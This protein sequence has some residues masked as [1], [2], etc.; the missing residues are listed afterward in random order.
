[1]HII[2]LFVIAFYLIYLNF[3]SVKWK[4]KKNKRYFIMAYNFIKIEYYN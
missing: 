1:M 2:Y 3:N 4:Y